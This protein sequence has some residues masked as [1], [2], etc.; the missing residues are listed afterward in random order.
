MFPDVIFIACR[1]V[2]SSSVEITSDSEDWSGIVTDPEEIEDEAVGNEIALSNPARSITKTLFSQ[3]GETKFDLTEVE[4]LRGC[5]FTHRPKL[6]QVSSYTTKLCRAKIFILVH[7]VIT[8]EVCER[9]YVNYTGKWTTLKSNVQ[10]PSVITN[11][12]LWHASSLATHVRLV[13]TF[14][15][16]WVNLQP[17][18]QVRFGTVLFI[19]SCKYR[20][21]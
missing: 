4:R 11:A 2:E 1:S 16:S 9:G 5:Q 21:S 19:F 15:L 18:S 13:C 7:G 8:E 14:D 6:P 12:N 10:E 17:N 20:T 3:H